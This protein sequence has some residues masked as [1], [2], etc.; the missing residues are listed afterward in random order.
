MTIDH[1]RQLAFDVRLPNKRFDF[2]VERVVLLRLKHEDVAVQ[3]APPQVARKIDD[4]R[5]CRAR[6]LDVSGLGHSHHL[7]NRR[8]WVEHV[9]EQMRT[10]HVVER[11]VG[12]G[13]VG[14]IGVE[15]GS[16]AR[17]ACEPER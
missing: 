6:H 14:D 7:A 17:A 3:P 2:W 15:Q 8:R 12:K 13:H 9:L 10:D 11:L 16:R 1:C 4:L 5:T